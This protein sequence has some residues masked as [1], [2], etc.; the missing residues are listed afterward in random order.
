MALET[1]FS[2]GINVAAFLDPE[3][4]DVLRAQITVLNWVRRVNF[5]R[6]SDSMKVRKR[7]TMTATTATE[8]T[9][10]ALSEYTQ[11]LLATLQVQEVKVYAE[12]SD[13]GREFSAIT[14][15]EMAQEAATAVLQYVEQA[16]C[17]LFDGFSRSVGT[18]G[19]Q[20]T[21]QVLRRA[22]YNLRVA[23]VP[24]PYVIVLHPTQ[25]DDVQDNIQSAGAALWGNP[26]VDF[27]ILNGAPV[28]EN[29]LAGS[30]LQVP[31]YSTTN[32]ESINTDAD[33]SG[34]ALNPQRAIAFGEDGRGIRSEVDRNIKK[35]VTQLAVNL[36][37]DVK[38]AEDLSG[39][40]I[41]SA[42]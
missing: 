38:E 18:T 1:E 33:W 41:V 39:V 16:T 25:I 2:N 9:D 29:G 35:G 4:M 31:V 24:G 40:G 17:G 12:L 27:S 26:M 5:Q 3:I 20:L 34:A 22:L 37:F 7:G 11:S 36:F 8:S 32:C 42:Q 15:E 19:E 28:K 30:Y 6:P 21:P 13:K 14:L 23:D 10:H